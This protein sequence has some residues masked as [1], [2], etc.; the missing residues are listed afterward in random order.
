MFRINAR[1]LVGKIWGSSVMAIPPRPTRRLWLEVLE[2][3]TLPS[4]S[5]VD[6]QPI[7]STDSPQAVAAAAAITSYLFTMTEQS[8]ATIEQDL[9]NA[10]YVVGQVIAQEVDAFDE[11]VD[12]FFGINLGASNPSNSGSGSVSGAAT[13]ARNDPS[14][15]L[16]TATP[17]SGSGMGMGMGGGSC[18]YYNRVVQFDQYQPVDVSEDASMCTPNSVTLG[19]YVVNPNSMCPPISVDYATQDGSAT[20]GTD[21]TTVSGTLEFS[22]G[23]SSDDYITVPILDDG[24]D[25]DAGSQSFYVVLSNPV[26]A[27]LGS[28]S[29]VTVNVDE[30]PQQQAAT[31][32]LLWNPC[33]GNNA[34]TVQNW[35]DVTQ[36]FQLQAGA[37][38]PN[39]SSPIQFDANPADTPN[40]NA[41][42]TWDQSFTVASISFNQYS[43][44][45]TINAGVVVE[46][47]GANG[48]S[49]SMDGTSYLYL[50]FGDSNSK[51]QID[52]NATITNMVLGGNSSGQ[53]I[54]EGGT[55]SMAQSPS[56]GETLGVQFIVYSG[57]IVN[58][59]SN[60]TLALTQD[61]VTIRVYG[62]MD[63][64]YGTN[65]GIN[66]IGNGNQ[67]TQSYIDVS[68]GT[69]GYYGRQNVKD[70]ITVPIA[71]HGG[72]TLKV[73]V[74]GNSGKPLQGTLI[75]QGANAS[76]NGVSVYLA[77]ALSSVQLSN[78]DTLECD[79][80]YY[81]GSGTLETTDATSC[82]LMAGSGAIQKAT[83][84]GGAVIINQPNVGYGTLNVT[85]AALNFNG[86]LVVAMDASKPN[87]QGDCDLLNVT[88]CATNLQPASTLMVYVQN[89][90][91]QANQGPWVIIQD[92]L[93]NNITGDFVKPITTT[94]QTNL[95]AQVDPDKPTQYILKS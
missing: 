4:A 89:G 6:S 63:F 37:Q 18:T 58:Y 51:F 42:I 35:Y 72:G 16:G 71:V 52:K 61:N 66:L 77:G 10:L 49:L 53:F 34:S 25:E 14:Q 22:P 47:S 13:T 75:V 86:Q 78:Y 85:A 70:T 79:S 44:P 31:D 7:S 8:I 5:P 28:P 56:Y 12:S 55:T 74:S 30:A 21:Y 81:Q 2:D 92:G 9:S 29:S 20:A 59:Q 24:N 27:I 50:L 83:I 33:I 65:N 69:L 80:G 11:G 84:A 23:Q 48:T 95:T 82:T 91:P 88:S 54:I 45:Q 46:S 43:G 36:G 39:P 93:N 17:Q 76:T 67:F 1:K 26:N 38:G 90:P 94:P 19:V 87:Q 64:F 73:S 3:R 60:C 57:A 15:A 32:T 68:G 62:E 40:S 41:P